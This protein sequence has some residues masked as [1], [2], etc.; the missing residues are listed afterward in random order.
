MLEY[1]HL[2][3]NHLHHLPDLNLQFPPHH[4]HLD[5]P[6]FLHLPETRL[7][8]KHNVR[9][10]W[11]RYNRNTHSCKNVRIA[12][13]AIMDFNLQTDYITVMQMLQ[14]GYNLYFLGWCN[15]GRS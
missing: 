2:H 13:N 4:L 11:Q 5:P 12:D 9:T 1:M 6:P 15:S 10:Q 8:P 3:N 14:K 7:F